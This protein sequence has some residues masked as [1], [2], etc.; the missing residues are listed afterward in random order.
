MPLP[1]GLRTRK[2]AWSAFLP[3]KK[4]THKN[5]VGLLSTATEVSKML[6]TVMEDGYKK[7]NSSCMR[8]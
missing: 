6:A 2:W 4:K 8:L 7:L 3:F 5:Y 1:Q